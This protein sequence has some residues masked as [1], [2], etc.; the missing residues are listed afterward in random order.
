MTTL[1]SMHDLVSN[2]WQQLEWG[3]ELKADLKG[4]LSRLDDFNTG[5]I[6]LTLFDHSNNCS[7]IDVCLS[8]SI[9]ML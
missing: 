6:Q 8:L 3:S 2:L 4:T 7:A 9:Q 5:K 1:L